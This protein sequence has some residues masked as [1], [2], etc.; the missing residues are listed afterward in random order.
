MSDELSPGF[1]DIH[2][3]QRCFR[4][5][6]DAMSHPGRTR[7]L[8]EALDPPPSLSVAAACCLLALTDATVL[9]ALPDDAANLQVFHT[10]A[11]LAPPS[12]ADFIVARAPI[13]ITDFSGGTD[14]EP[15]RGATLLLDVPALDTGIRVRLSGPG[16][17]GSIT[18]SLPLT[19]D[20]IRQWRDQHDRA[21]CGIDVILCAGRSLLAMPRSVMMEAI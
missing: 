4:A 21:P 14:E 17:A 7:T 16:I 18:I 9:V 1:N 6:L 3:S 20:F 10:G 8:D 12:R 19:T 13:A 15:E 5:I 2:A 11:G